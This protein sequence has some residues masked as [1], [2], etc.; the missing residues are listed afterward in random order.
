[1]QTELSAWEEAKMDLYYE[2]SLGETRRLPDLLVLF[3]YWVKICWH[4]IKVRRSPCGQGN[5]DW[6][7]QSTAGP[8]SGN[9]HLVCRHCGETFHKN[10]Y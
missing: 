8:D 5:H 1:M 6:D 4:R 7:D 10:L 2:Q 9:I 3:Q